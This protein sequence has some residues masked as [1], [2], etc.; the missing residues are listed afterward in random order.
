MSA[1][2]LA[3]FTGHTPRTAKALWH[4]NEKKGDVVSADFARDMEREN[5]NLRASLEELVNH[6]TKYGAAPLSAVKMFRRARE[7]LAG[8][9]SES[10]QL[11]AELRASQAREAELGKALA[12]VLPLA[13]RA[14]RVRRPMIEG[15][16]GIEQARALLA[17]KG[18]AA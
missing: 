13:E 17:K 12:A 15:E 4:F 18:G 7:A 2:D 9:L 3:Q 1:L 6:A 16:Q 10:P 5:V 8:S 14:A 11:L